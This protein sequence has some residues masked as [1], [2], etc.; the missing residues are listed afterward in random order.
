MN[1][2]RN[3]DH[4]CIIV[5]S[6]IRG[7]SGKKRASIIAWYFTITNVKCHGSQTCRFALRNVIEFADLGV[8]SLNSARTPPSNTQCALLGIL[9]FQNY[10]TLVPRSRL[11]SYLNTGET[12]DNTGICILFSCSSQPAN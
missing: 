9:K 11:T 4:E 10:R 12:T 2:L 7:L 5:L 3:F 8:L 6:S 1:I